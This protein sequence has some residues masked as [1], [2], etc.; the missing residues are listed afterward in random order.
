M[1][2]VVDVSFRFVNPI[3]H[4]FCPLLLDQ[5]TLPTKIGYQLYTVMAS[6]YACVA[7]TLNIF[8]LYTMDSVGDVSVCSK[9]SFKMLMSTHTAFIYTS[10]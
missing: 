8:I 4:K 6:I 10:K 5:D 1:Y 3:S 7:Y 9:T 2:S